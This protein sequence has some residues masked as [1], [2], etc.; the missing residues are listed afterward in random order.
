[1]KNSYQCKWMCNIRLFK[2]FVTKVKKDLSAV[3]LC[4]IYDLTSSF[5]KS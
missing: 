1:M 3:R 4:T 5:L 2:K